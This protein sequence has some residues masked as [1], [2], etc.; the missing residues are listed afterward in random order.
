MFQI[1]QF[2]LCWTILRRC[3]TL[4][5]RGNEIVKSQRHL[6]CHCRLVWK[7]GFVNW[8]NLSSWGL[9]C[10][11]RSTVKDAERVQGLETS[12]GCLFRKFGPYGN[13]RWTY[14]PRH[15]I[16]SWIFLSAGS[17]S[18]KRW[19]STHFPSTGSF[20][21]VMPFPH[22]HDIQIFDQNQ[23]GSSRPDSCGTGLASATVVASNNGTSMSTSLGHP[24][25]V[26]AVFGSTGQL[27]PSALLAVWSLSG[28]ASKQE[29]FRTKWSSFS[30]EEPWC[31]I[32]LLPEFLEWLAQLVR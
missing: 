9:K 32:S 18:R 19:R 3:I 13:P 6:G 27:P 1:Y 2:V 11:C 20:W 30:W 10:P 21:R 7:A 12:G 17:H 22:Q 29:A 26:D 28:T 31:H 23:E 24:P 8:S 25:G 16:G 4:I 15:G 14:S 5:R